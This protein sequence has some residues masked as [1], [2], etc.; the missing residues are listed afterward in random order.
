MIHRREGGRIGAASCEKFAVGRIQPKL[1]LVG[2]FVPFIRW[3]A[4]SCL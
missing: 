3:D 2:E 1:L 4:D